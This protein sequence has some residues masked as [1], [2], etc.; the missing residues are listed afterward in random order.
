MVINGNKRILLVR[1]ISLAKK[2][3]ISGGKS[4][5][6]TRYRFSVSKSG[7][8][9]HFQQIFKNAQPKKSSI[10]C[11]SSANAKGQGR[12][13]PLSCYAVAVHN[14]VL[15]CT[16]FSVFARYSQNC[17]VS[18]KNCAFH[19]GNYA[20]TLEQRAA[21]WLYSAM[22]RK[23]TQIE[24]GLNFFC[25]KFFFCGFKKLAKLFWSRLT[26]QKQETK[27]PAKIFFIFIVQK[28]C[29]A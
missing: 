23:K 29:I 4:A 21:V 11:F 28:S 13:S 24:S 7:Y 8:N 12:A 3:C 15:S 20:Q 6:C 16:V 19:G 2:C 22:S 25:H 14:A 10:L 17:A 27:Y 9:Q 5:R 1:I 18:A 26:A